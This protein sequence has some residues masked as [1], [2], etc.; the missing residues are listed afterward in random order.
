[1]PKAKN[2]RT[3]VEVKELPAQEEQKNSA[4]KTL[5]YLGANG[6]IANETDFIELIRKGLN[7]K[8][9]D[10]LLLLTG[11]P[12][13]EIA[14]FIH[15]S[16]RTLRRYKPSTLLSPKQSERILEIAT[17]YTHGGEVFGDMDTFKEWIN[18]DL[19]ALGNKKPKDFLDTSRGVQMIDALL[20]RIEHGIFS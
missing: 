1:M 8:A 3:A 11:L 5:Q 17:L 2:L 4:Y 19:M 7:R 12:P 14:A 18:T 15:V 6:E 9:L 13:S 20:G 10:R 16:D